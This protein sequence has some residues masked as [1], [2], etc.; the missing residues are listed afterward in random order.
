MGIEITVGSLEEMCDL[1]CNNALPKEKKHDK[2]NRKDRHG[3]MDEG[4]TEGAEHE[5]RTNGV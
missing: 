1:M 4:E 2:R 5:P 3:Q